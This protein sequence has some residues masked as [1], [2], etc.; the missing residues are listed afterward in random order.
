MFLKLGRVVSRRWY[1]VILAWVVLAIFLPRAAPSWN[2][3]THDGDLAYLP[4]E[5]P[6]V[7]GQRLLSEAFPANR[8]KSQIVVVVARREG[9][10]EEQE[11]K[12]AFGLVERID[13]LCSRHQLPILDVWS[14][15]DE[16]FGR[17]LISEDGAAR[18]ILLH[19]SNEFLATDNIR[20]LEIPPF[21]AMGTPL[22]L[23]K[24]FGSKA[25]FEQAVH[26]LQSALYQESA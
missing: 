3:I 18:L 12:A 2:S 26:E 23:I 17:K 4:A 5:M 15:R 21:S 6:S 25:R 10:F 13:A 20:V 14:W 16:E 1:W 19:L 8:S 7:V 24:Q 9:R 11:L 22:Q